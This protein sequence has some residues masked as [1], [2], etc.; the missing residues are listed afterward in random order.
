M[1]FALHQ[2]EV[3]RVAAFKRV[4]TMPMVEIRSR[5]TAAR[6][7]CGDGHVGLMGPF[8]GMCLLGF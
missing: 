5:K 7:Q 8:G 1:D 2:V 4:P 3:K 6:L